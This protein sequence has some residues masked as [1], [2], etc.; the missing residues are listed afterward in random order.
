MT[1][2]QYL[3]IKDAL[4]TQIKAGGLTAHDKLPSER[5]LGELYGTTRVT[6]REALVQLEANGLIYRQDRRGWFVTPPRFRLNPRRTSNFHQIVSEQG[7]KP[8][9]EL[10]EK[11]RIAVP[12]ALLSR[13]SLKTFDSVFLLKRLRF[14]N[15]RAICYCENYCLPKR[16][17]GLLDL[18]LNGSLTELY[19][20]HYG[21]HYARMQVTFY[22]TALPDEVASQLRATAGLP[23]LRLE[24]LNFDQHG[25]VLD[26]DLEYWRHDSLEIDVDTQD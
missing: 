10:L 12:P 7:G 2:P 14:A 22:P 13:L 5:L 19:Q 6:I 23:A 20:S 25:Q 26:F 24:R 15:D 3:Q 18:D 4:I 16:V 1:K 17:P 11:S 8:R 21:L 9:T